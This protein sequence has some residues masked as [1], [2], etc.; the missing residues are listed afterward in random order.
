VADA[1]GLA[2]VNVVGNSM[3][4]TNALEFAISHPDRTNKVVLIS[5]VGPWADQPGI[6]PRG[7]RSADASEN[8]EINWF[9]SQ[10]LDPATADEPGFFEWWVASRSASDDEMIRA[11]RARPLLAR[12][13]A[14][15]AAPTLL[16]IGTHDPLH[17]LEWARSWVG[18]LPRGTVKQIG[19]ARHFLNLEQ[20]RLLAG[21]M[22]D[23]LTDAQ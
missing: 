21:A 8:K 2:R 13:L 3:S 23:F 9:R 7:T 10:F 15:C 6:P 5:G 14:E 16:I 19:P 20:P 22:L 11:W 18:L 4:G 1:L 12:S 17:P